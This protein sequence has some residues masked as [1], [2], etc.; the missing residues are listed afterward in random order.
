MDIIGDHTE[1]FSANVGRL[2]KCVV[3]VEQINLLN[4]SIDSSSPQGKTKLEHR[5]SSHF[6]I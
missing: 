3:Q 6:Q 1:K 4:A 2:F 5:A